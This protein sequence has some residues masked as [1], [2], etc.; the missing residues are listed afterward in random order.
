MNTEDQN[1][2]AWEI[3]HDRNVLVY[4]LIHTI[5]AVVL[6]LCI[7]IGGVV[8]GFIWYLNQYDFTSTETVNTTTHTNSIEANTEGGGDASAII[9]GEG[10]VIINGESKGNSN[11]KIHNN[12]ENQ[13]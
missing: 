11:S 5:I 13:E 3:V 2:L 12:K 9:N 1:S 10:E 6:M 8:G 4:K 7:T